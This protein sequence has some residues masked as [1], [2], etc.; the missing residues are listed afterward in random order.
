MKRVGSLWDRLIGL[1][2][3]LRSAEAAYKG[4]P[5]RDFTTPAAAFRSARPSRRPL[6][7]L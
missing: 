2:N 6:D 1:E 3:L 5:G 4:N 7:A